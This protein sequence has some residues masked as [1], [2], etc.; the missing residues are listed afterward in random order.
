MSPDDL[1]V[2]WDQLEED[3]PIDVDDCVELAKALVL[4]ARRTALG[5]RE[6]QQVFQ[7]FM[8]RVLHDLG[9][10]EG[11]FLELYL[12]YSAQS[13]EILVGTGVSLHEDDESDRFGYFGV[14]LKNPQNPE[15]VVV[16]KEHRAR[17]EMHKAGSF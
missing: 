10:Q 8:A 15:H 11:L 1:R 12:P 14:D 2:L 17:L 7:M 16:G 9:M 5:E 13:G 3:G 4:V 6:K